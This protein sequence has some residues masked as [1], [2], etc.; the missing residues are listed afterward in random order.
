M[1][2]VT[3]NYLQYN[4]GN[5]GVLSFF[6]EG[7]EIIGG[8]AGDKYQNLTAT[9]AEEGGMKYIIVGDD[10]GNSQAFD[11]NTITVQDIDNFV[12]ADPPLQQNPNQPPVIYNEGIRDLPVHAVHHK[13]PLLKPEDIIKHDYILCKTIN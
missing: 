10:N 11:L 6:L 4:T 3:D 9:L 8:G 1:Y 13:E 7:T 2:I 5:G 12:N